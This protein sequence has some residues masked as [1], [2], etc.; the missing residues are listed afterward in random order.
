MSFQRSLPHLLHREFHHTISLSSQHSIL[1]EIP[2]CW[3]S[4]YLSYWMKAPL[5]EQ[6]LIDEL[7]S[8]ILPSAWH[9]YCWMNEWRLQCVLLSAESGCP[10]SVRVVPSTGNCSKPFTWVL[11]FPFLWYIQRYREDR[12]VASLIAWG[13]PEAG[14]R[15]KNEWT[16]K[17]WSN[18]EFA[19]Y[20]SLLSLLNSMHSVSEILFFPLAFFL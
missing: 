2:I 13:D 20:S 18:W 10:G 7:I 6:G 11:L 8:R 12:D 17:L 19:K 1:S 15:K 4:P 16:L 5:M 3:L 14:K 9:S